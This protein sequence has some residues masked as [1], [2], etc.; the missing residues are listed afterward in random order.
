[1]PICDICAKPIIISGMNTISSAEIK[2]KASKGFVPSSL[3]KSQYDLCRDMGIS[4][5]VFWK[6]TVEN[7]TTDW[8]LCQKCFAETN[9]YKTS[10]WK[11][12]F[13]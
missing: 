5:G 6:M 8:G 3:P 12:L 7:N 4:I 11:R 1:M 10:F 2:E 13:Q 9:N